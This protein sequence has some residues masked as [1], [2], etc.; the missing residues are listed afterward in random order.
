[1]ELTKVK[2]PE[3][4]YSIKCPYSM[5][6]EFYIVHNTAND[7][8]AM[9]EVSYMLGNSNYVSFNYAID[10][11]RIVQGIEENR[12]TWNCGDGTNGNGNRHGI[13]IEICYSKSGGD[14]FN[15]AEIL[16]AEF[17]AKGLQEKGWGIDRVKKHQDFNGKYCPHKTLDLGWERFLNLISSKMS[18][19][20][21]TPIP[22]PT[23]ITPTPVSYDRYRISKQGVNFR[24]GASLN[25]KVIKTLPLGHEFNVYAIVDGFLKTDGGYIK[26]G[27]A[28]KISSANVPQPVKPVV[29]TNSKWTHRYKTNATLNVHSTP[30]L[31]NVVKLYKQGTIFDIYEEKNGFGHSPSGWIKLSYCTKIW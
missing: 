26:V 12:N 27:Y 18:I 9:S 11:F 15:K 29:N 20:T 8:S 3:S 31:G 14:R 25:S 17:I 16:A 22:Q 7:A 24:S 19:I 4:K 28:D 6:G 1:M 5:I 10:D 21:P 23:P 30:S 2:C 13:S